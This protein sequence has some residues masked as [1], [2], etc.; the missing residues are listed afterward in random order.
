MTLVNTVLLSE[1]YT[2]KGCSIQLKNYCM[3]VLYNKNIE[4]DDSD[5][6]DCR[7]LKAILDKIMSSKKIKVKKKKK[8][9]ISNPFALFEKKLFFKYFQVYKTMS[10]TKINKK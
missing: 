7:V 5:K 3:H 10:K 1:P 9:R 4:L 8:K 6:R 2:I